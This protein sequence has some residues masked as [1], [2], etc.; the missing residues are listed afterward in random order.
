MRIIH[1]VWGDGM[2][3][4]TRAMG[5]DETVTVIIETDRLKRHAASIPKLEI[6]K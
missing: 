6:E 5:N 4:E 1:P 2:V 3:I